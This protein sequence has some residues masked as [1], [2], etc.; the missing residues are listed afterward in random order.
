[1]EEF[2]L[3]YIVHYAH[4]LEGVPVYI[5]GWVYDVESGEVSDL[6]VSAGPSGKEV[7]PTPFP[8]VGSLTFLKLMCLVN[9]GSIPTRL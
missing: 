7:P 9:L 2:A 3:I 8:L 4:D 6:G 5:H 1:M